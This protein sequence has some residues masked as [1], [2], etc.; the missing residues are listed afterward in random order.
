MRLSIPRPR[1]L[2]PTSV[3]TPEDWI[4]EVDS[5]DKYGY[6]EVLLIGISHWLTEEQAIER[7]NRTLSFKGVT[8]ADIRMQRRWQRYVR[9]EPDDPERRAAFTKEVACP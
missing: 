2:L 1:K 5:I 7:V 3:L 4:A 9:V 6:R 8:A